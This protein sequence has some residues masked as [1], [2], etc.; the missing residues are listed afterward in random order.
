MNITFIGQQSWLI[1]DQDTYVIIDPLLTETF[2]TSKEVQ[3]R[4]YPPR[5]VS[6][7]K[8]PKINAVLIT[9]EHL[10]HFH[11]KSLKLLD[12]SIPI[13]IGKVMPNCVKDTIKKIGFKAI[14]EVNNGERILINNL[15]VYFFIGDS[16]VP[17][18]EKR[19]YQVYVVNSMKFGV[20]I[21]SDTLINNYFLEQINNRTIPSPNVYIT[22]NNSQLLPLEYHGAFD[23]LLP[24]SNTSKTGLPGLNILEEVLVQYPKQLLSLSHILISGG[25]YIIDNEQSKPFLYTDFNLV[26]SYLKELSLGLNAMYLSPGEQLS[27]ENNNSYVN[28][29]EWIKIDDN[30]FNGYNNHH[31]KTI[32]ESLLTEP[33]FKLLNTEGSIKENINLIKSELENLVPSLLLS[34]LGKLLISTNEYIEGAINSARFVINLKKDKNNSL[35]FTFNINSAKFELIEGNPEALLRKFPYGIELFVGDFIALIT[36]KIQIWELATANMRQWYLGDKLTSPVSFLYCHFSE[37]VRPDLAYKIYET[38]NAQ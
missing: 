37:Q 29:V 13:Y 30:L 19:V 38:I 35:I 11:L 22:T 24:V 26:N 16:N 1:N 5:N 23:N 25:G 32:E 27:F 31:N 12:K 28:K 7:N 3:F 36:G 9:N 14:H 2:G 10:D 33:I 4:V 18:W 21:Q 17:F 6:L 20:F 8:M 15:S 34:K